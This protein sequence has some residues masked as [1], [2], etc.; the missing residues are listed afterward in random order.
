MAWEERYATQ[1]EPG[2]E[3]QVA[4]GTQQRAWLQAHTEE[5]RG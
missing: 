3:G 4:F 5:Y 2:R 1:R